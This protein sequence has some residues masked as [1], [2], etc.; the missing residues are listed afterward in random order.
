MFDTTPELAPDLEWM[1][2]DGQVSREMLAE[3]LVDEHYTGV[4]SLALGVLDDLL[5]AQE[6]AQQVFITALAEAYR[7]RGRVN[8]TLWLYQIALRVCRQA[9]RSL[10]LQRSVQATLPGADGS[11]ALGASLPENEADASLWLALDALDLESRLVILLHNLLAWD[12]HEI[13]ALFAVD[14]KQAQEGLDTLYLRLSPE[15]ETPL[16]VYAL[17]ASLQRRWPASAF[18]EDGQQALAVQVAR[19]AGQE[20]ARRRVR[21]LVGELALVVLAVLIGL[22]SI[23]ALNLLSS[24]NETAAGLAP[25]TQIITKLVPVEVTRVQVITHTLTI[26]TLAAL[27]AVTATPDLSDIL[28]TTHLGDTLEGIA[29][30]LNV[31]LDDLRRLNRLP[32]GAELQRDQT[33][34]IPGK[35]KLAP[36]PTPTPVAPLPQAEVLSLSFKVEEVLQI[37][38][39]WGGPLVSTLWFDALSI[40]YGPPGY[41]GPPR[42]RRMQVWWNGPEK[43]LLLGGPVDGPLDQVWLQTEGQLY[44]AEPALDR[45]QFYAWCNR[46]SLDCTIGEIAAAWYLRDNT[47]DNPVSNAHLNDLFLLLSPGMQA[48]ENLSPWTFTETGS[49]LVAGRMALK[50]DQNIKAGPLAYRLWLDNATGLILRRQVMNRNDEKRVDYEVLVTDVAYDVDF[51]PELFDPRLPWRGGFARDHTGVIDEQPYT[52]PGDYTPALQNIDYWPPPPDGFDD[53]RGRLL[54][55]YPGSYETDFASI[56]VNVFI[57]EYYLGQAV[58]GDPWMMICDRSP[59]GRRIAYASLF[60]RFSIQKPLLRWFDLSALTGNAYA[61]LETVAV[62][63]LAFAPDSARL[64]VFGYPDSPKRNS[65]PGELYI[66]DLD[67]GSSI[68]L[69]NLGDAKSLVWKPD[70]TQLAL[71]ARLYADSYEEQILV[72]DA[73]SGTIVYNSPV[74]YQTGGGGEWPMV[75]WGVEFPVGIGGLEQ[76]AAP[77]P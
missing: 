30:D 21:T 28:Y 69:I 8:A 7:Y 42:V 25:A 36:Y 76:C 64:A 23:W 49:E 34:V 53:Y 26:T 54:F 58:L 4:Y 74:D 16:D 33:L 66:I 73:S 59:D 14:E 6:T 67:L 47:S 62:S 61:A 65:A 15:E 70:G 1:L 17:R 9:W 57:D 10:H 18:T 72:V 51:S 38:S 71:I 40:A 48:G 2:Q 31:S 52:L 45:S 12:L 32:P 55:H 11:A 50:I 3:A 37:V 56:P 68:S 43:F 63:E 46:N 5:R 41:S 13:A 77:L 35:L 29:G 39:Q 22:G 20:T 19:R 60:W 44:L 27:G 75:E 24:G